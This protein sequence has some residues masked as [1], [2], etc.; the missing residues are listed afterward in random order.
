M[1]LLIWTPD[2]YHHLTAQSHY[3]F[4]YLFTQAG[5][6]VARGRLTP[7]RTTAPEATTSD[8][9]HSHDSQQ[10][11]F[12]SFAMTVNCSGLP[13]RSVPRTSLVIMILT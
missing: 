6:G 11:A 1:Y 7:R 13:A 10:R 2:H 9:C 3:L 4:T 8:L 12:S 5:K